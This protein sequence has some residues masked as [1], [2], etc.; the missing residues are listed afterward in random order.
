ML[1][2]PPFPLFGA[3]PSPSPCRRHTAGQA[4]PCFFSR[5]QGLLFQASGPGSSHCPVLPLGHLTGDTYLPFKTWLPLPSPRS[6]PC[7]TPLVG[8]VP[9]PLISYG[10]P[11]LRHR[12]NTHTRRRGDAQQVLGR[13]GVPWPGILWTCPGP[14]Q[15]QEPSSTHFQ[16]WPLRFPERLL[17]GSIA[18]G[19]QWVRAGEKEFSCSVGLSMAG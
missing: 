11:V 10:A 4:W 15:E 18:G 3:S 19:W 13:V 6:L 1:T 2:Y 14:E 8:G 16:M 12:G 9:S 17:W 7:L 5:P